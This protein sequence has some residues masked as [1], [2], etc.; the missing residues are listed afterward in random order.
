MYLLAMNSF[1]EAQIR[2][3]RLQIREFGPADADL[4]RELVDAA[5]PLALPPGAPSQAEGIAEWL[6]D[7]VHAPRRNGAG[8]L[9]MMLDRASDRIVGSIAL[10][11]VDWEVRSAEIGYG[12]RGDERGK[13]YA[14]EAL[15]AVGR[16]ALSAGGIQ[17]AWLTANTDNVASV[18]VAEKAGFTREGTLRRA[19]LEDDGLLHDQ[20]LFSLLD[21]EA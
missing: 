12:V 8:L 17:R 16:W 21:D 5:E 14:T 19:A 7:G 2:A 20:A 18:R 1:P 15:A 4:V 9:L 10:F 6:A 3:E 11:H 13:G